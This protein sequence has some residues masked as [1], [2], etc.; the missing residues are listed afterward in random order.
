MCGKNH[1]HESS[2]SYWQ[3]LHMFGFYHTHGSSGNQCFLSS[4]FSGRPSEGSFESQTNATNVTL[5]VN[6]W[7]YTV[8]KN[9]TNA[10]NVTMQYASSVAGH[11]RRHLKTYSGEKSNKCNQV[12]LHSHR[13][14]I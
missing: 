13:H 11:F 9:Q 12:T 3:F 6:I 8:Q 1:T 2:G 14:A 4:K 5:P 7:K 10:T